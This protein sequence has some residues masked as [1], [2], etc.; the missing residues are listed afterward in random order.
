MGYQY[1]VQYT[2]HSAHILRLTN[3][4][5]STHATR[6]EFLASHRPQ[7][8]HR[9]LFSGPSGALHKHATGTR[10]KHCWGMG[11]TCNLQAD[12]SK[13]HINK[14]KPTRKEVGRKV[15]QN[16]E[17]PKLSAAPLPGLGVK[18]QMAGC[19]SERRTEKNPEN[20]GR[21]NLV[22]K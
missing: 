3:H 1:I 5:T 7:H 17:R 16:L 21:R 19:P 20:T 15:G 13:K 12:Q 18:H 10:Y 11:A 6:L 9:R 14:R 8:H 4:G 2:V 22:S